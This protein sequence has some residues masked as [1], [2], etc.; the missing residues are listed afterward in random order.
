MVYRLSSLFD[1]NLTGSGSQPLSFDQLAAVYQKYL[2]LKCDWEV[3][4]TNLNS[5]AAFI[6]VVPTD[7]T[8]ASAS[9][10]SLSEIKRSVTRA[11]SINSGGQATVTMRGSVD[12]SDLHGQIDLD[13]DSSQYSLVS[14]NP[15]DTAFLTIRAA[16]YTTATSISVGIR[17]R[18]TYYAVFKEYALVNES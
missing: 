6:T 8:V 13:A 14:T 10:Q 15:S 7:V 5:T 16:D 11:L 12:M 3:Q 1:P 17:V 9:M 4:A 18:L 2:V